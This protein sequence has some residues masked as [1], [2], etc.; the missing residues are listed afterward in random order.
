MI[1]INENNFYSFLKRYNNCHPVFILRTL[2]K[3][4]S[5]GKTFDLLEDFSGKN[6]LVWDNEKNTWKEIV[7]SEYSIVELQETNAKPDI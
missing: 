4:K 2:E 7:I 1:E 5:L 3:T 6:N